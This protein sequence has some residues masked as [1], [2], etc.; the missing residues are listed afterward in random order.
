MSYLK[1]LFKKFQYS[2]TEPDLDKSANVRFI[3]QKPK[4]G[5]IG[6]DL[7]S[8]KHYFNFK[9]KT[10]VNIFGGGVEDSFYLQKIQQLDLDLKQCI[11]WGVG[12]SIKNPPQPHFIEKLPFKYWGLRDIDSVEKNFLPC[13]SCLH[14]MLD[15]PQQD[16]KTLIFLNFDKKVTDQR[17]F[18]TIKEKYHQYSV[19]Y[20]NCDNESFIHKFQQSSHIITNSF[21]GTYWGL[22]AGKSV[23]LI[24][25]SSKFYSLYKMF[26]LDETKIIS[27]Q[28]CDGEGL[29]NAIELATQNNHWQ[30]LNDSE[31]IK[32]KFR[33]IN[34][35]FADQLRNSDYFES[36]DLKEEQHV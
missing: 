16:S 11:L 19:I 23:T 5:N 22:L 14:P 12:Q 13:V 33:K 21:H 20:N 25:Y 30:Q 29:L 2:L 7:C 1:D 9:A 6:D 17:M 8:P 3:H 34:L 18:Q 32:D 31:T 26:N 10:L 4:F 35:Q 36:I 15:L 24:G 27:V 28:R